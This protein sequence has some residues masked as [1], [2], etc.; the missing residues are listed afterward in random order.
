[1]NNKEFLPKSAGEIIKTKNPNTT[2]S[3]PSTEPTDTYLFTVPFSIHSL[4]RESSASPYK[5]QTNRKR[6][7][8]IWNG[9]AKNNYAVHHLVFTV[10]QHVT[11]AICFKFLYFHILIYNIKMQGTGIRKM[12]KLVCFT[13]ICEKKNV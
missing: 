12:W 4:V 8:F 3:A 1:M 13:K 11:C 7:D 2:A 6:S 10:I 5:N 9:S